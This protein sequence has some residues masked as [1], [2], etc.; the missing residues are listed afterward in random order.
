MTANPHTNWYWNDWDADQALA[1][2][3]LAAQG[4]W[5]RMLSIA[6]KAG[7][8]VRV[9]GTACTIRDIAILV[10][11]S[12]E[13]I[14]PLVAELGERGVYSRTRDGTIYNRRFVRDEKN[15]KIA[16]KN[17]RKG[18]NPLLLVNHG[19]QT[20]ISR[21]VNPRLNGQDKPEDKPSRARVLLPQTSKEESK[22][23]SVAP[24]GSTVAEATEPPPP[25]EISRDRVKEVWDRGVTVLGKSSRSLI[26]KCRRDYGDLAVMEALLATE[27]E[28]ASHPVEF[29]VGWMRR[30]QRRCQGFSYQT[31]PGATI[32]EAANNII[33]SLQS[34]DP[35]NGFAVVEPL[36][37]GYG[38]GAGATR[39]A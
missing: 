35:G 9:N 33:R 21:G 38:T 24:G 3:S 2:C 34:A 20:E 19:K 15:R 26:G 14:A 30:A 7:G 32:Y 39:A 27:A 12:T 18:G 11:R 22:E 16:Q 17:G 8:Y 4:L 1:L 13:E 36:L 31:A 5:M 23:D 28:C 29:F 6:S 25:A 37:A 10:G